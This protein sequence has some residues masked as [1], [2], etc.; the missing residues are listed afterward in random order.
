MGSL[1]K[2]NPFQMV[3]QGVIRLGVSTLSSC[4]KYRQ[5]PQSL[6]ASAGAFSKSRGMLST[7]SSY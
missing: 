4:R 1:V 6:D 2:E 3:Q 7:L 5:M